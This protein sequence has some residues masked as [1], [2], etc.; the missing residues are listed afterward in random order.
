MEGRERHVLQFLAGPREGF[1]MD[2][3]VVSSRFIFV[4]GAGATEFADMGLLLN[5]GPGSVY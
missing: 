5:V 4:F 2:C 1:E 3:R